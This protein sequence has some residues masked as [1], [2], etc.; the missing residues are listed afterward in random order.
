MW[1]EEHSKAARSHGW[2]VYEVW[3]GKKMQA[4]AMPV[5][6]S[7]RTPHV[8]AFA[9]WLN[10]LART[11]DELALTALRHVATRNMQ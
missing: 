3:T 5:T 10:N 7:K 8:P 6:F 1:T 11:R 2:D 9:A 4:I